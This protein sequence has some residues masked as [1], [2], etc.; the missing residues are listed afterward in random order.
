MTVLAHSVFHSKLSQRLNFLLVKSQQ[1]FFLHLF[2][3]GQSIT[4]KNT[5]NEKG[6]YLQHTYKMI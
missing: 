4:I 3:N 2:T 1:F 6:N 5:K